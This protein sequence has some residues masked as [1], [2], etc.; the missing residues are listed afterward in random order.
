[1]KELAKLEMRLARKAKNK[2][3]DRYET[4]YKGETIVIYFPQSI[5]RY[6]NE[7][8]GNLTVTIEN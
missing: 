3:G 2:G 1:M 5:S 8:I 6:E 7:S 4:D